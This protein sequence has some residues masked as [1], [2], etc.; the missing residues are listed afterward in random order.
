[1]FER[2][3]KNARRVVFFARYEASEYGSAYIETEHMLLGL[4]REDPFLMTKCLKPGAQG[5]EIRTEIE[6]HITRHE[7]ISTSVEVPLTDES[8][9][10]LELA[11]EESKRLGQRHIGTEHL[12]L[13]MLR[14]ETSL[15][16]KIL[17]ARGVNMEALEEQLAKGVD[18]GGAGVDS[19]RIK[20]SARAGIGRGPTVTL[21]RFLAG[22]KS[23]D[24]DRLAP[25]FARNV[26]FI[27]FSGKPWTGRDEIE[28]N[29]EVL[30]APYVKK[31]VTFLLESSVTEPAVMV[32]SILWEN[33]TA[34]GQSTRSM[35]RMTIVLAADE[36]DW[37]IVL[38]QMT[39]VLAR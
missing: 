22:L 13:G 5:T 14:M 32:A 39:P 33:V 1:M 26:Q 9:K 4:L 25:F 28:K 27:D 15:A 36:E 30:F 3:T 20:V 12:L 38:L 24:W 7:R 6:K 23:Y 37:A 17:R 21:N 31:D 8:K 10:I 34:G 19:G 29:F 35:H 2:Y 18:S 16:G 11:A